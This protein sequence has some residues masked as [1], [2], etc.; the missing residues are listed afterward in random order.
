MVR[1]AALASA[2]VLVLAL[3][4]SSAAQAGER[5]AELGLTLVGTVIRP[6]AAQSMATI[7]AKARDS[8]NNYYQTHKVPRVG[9]VKKIER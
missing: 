9:A 1:L 5:P 4:A 3:V 6:E 7:S 8:R 2:L